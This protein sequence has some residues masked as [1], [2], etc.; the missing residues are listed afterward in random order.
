[1]EDSGNDVGCKKGDGECAADLADIALVLPREMAQ[2]D[3][4]SLP[5]IVN[6]ALGV[7]QQGDELCIPRSWR[8]GTGLHDELCLHAPAFELDGDQEARRAIGASTR[9]YADRGFLTGG[10]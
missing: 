8:A 10:D 3:G 4:S 7:S 1:V 9:P 2:R 6:P 5:E